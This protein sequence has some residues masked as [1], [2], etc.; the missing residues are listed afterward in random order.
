MISIEELAARIEPTRTSL[1]LGA[2]ASA[3]SGAPTGPELASR[4]CDLL[5]K[6]VRISPDLIETC[7]I[8]ENKVGRKALVEKVRLLL[9]PLQPAGGL[10]LLPEFEW[11]AIYTTNF[12][13]L[14][15]A[16]FR[17][18]NRPLVTIRSNFEYS[19]TESSSG[20][21]LF[22]LHGCIS[23][24]QTNGDVVRLVLTERDYEE[25][26][27]FRE[28][29][30]R[31]L[32][33]DLLTK[34]LLVIGYSLKDPHIRRDMAEAA[35]HHQAGLTAGRLYALIYDT[36]PD[37][38][39]LLERKGFTI[40]F[41]G[42]DQFFHH[43][44]QA[45]P[46]RAPEEPPSGGSPI[47]LPP[48]IRPSSVEVQHAVNLAPNVVR[49]FNG[50]PATYADIGAGLTIERSVHQRLLGEL[51]VRSKRFLTI[52][53]VAGVGKTTLARR[54][55]LDLSGKGYAAWEHRSD[56][57]FRHT[58]WIDVDARMRKLGL[59]GVLLIDDCPEFL[60]QINLLVD[61]LCR[62]DDIALTVIMTASASGWLPRTKS[63]NLFKH[64]VTERLSFL[65]EADVEALVNLLASQ[66]S[67]RALVDI[68][69]STMSRP[70]QIR[71]LRYRCAA[72]MF[73]CLKSIFA[74][75]ALDDILLREYAVLEQSLQDIYRHVCALESAGTRVHRQLILRLLG[76][77]ADKIGSLL[78]LL[79]G[80]VE[81]YDISAE[82]GLYGWQTRHVV[83]ADTIARYKYADQEELLS[84]LR[85]VVENLNPAVYV[86]L[87]TVRD[88]CSE[89]GIGRINDPRGR[90][91][92]YQ[93][94]I[95]MAPGE[96]I[97]RHRLIAELLRLDELHEAEY[98]I[99]A[100]EKEVGSD[101]PIRRYSVRLALRR[102]FVTAGIMDEDR[103]A[104]MYQASALALK[105]I[106]RAKEDKY[107]YF[108]YGDVGLALV[109][110][111]GEVKVLDDAI[112]RM[113]VAAEFILDPHFATE[114][115]KLE[116]ERQRITGSTPPD[117]IPIEFPISN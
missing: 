99:K 101:S 109:E 55:V 79:E 49:L 115:T 91:E 37:R 26:Q 111:F 6:G 112:A 41:G 9:R 76:V 11:H 40:A 63:S 105:S 18:L 30:Y 53:G 22:K 72:D 44:G 71:R 50:G 66:P 117:Q 100:A 47:E 60:R 70:D 29:L 33:L 28:V 23:S 65:S 67:I 4:L 43:L 8:L 104:L 10:L 3:P 64:G 93:A 62:N 51:S 61:K 83:V 78:A 19:K 86:E 103:R 110:T 54:L 57:P 116:Q 7:S 80:L 58:A 89:Q 34:D 97:P 85:S 38:A 16:A 27:P 5:N 20:I 24:D 108:A 39:A 69:F 1:F 52:I 42:I 90:I 75:D 45:Q 106:G 25:Y 98:A 77:Q 73:V 15:E 74:S 2:G 102:A 59:R 46:P 95:A 35:R 12:D 113:R 32:A 107:G 96:R 94:L 68:G 48:I 114:L 36:D 81:E 92:L 31:R 88:L 56:F 17:R 82:D 14:V 87:R 21:P 13:R 84:L